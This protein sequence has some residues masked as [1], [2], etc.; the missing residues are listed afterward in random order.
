MAGGVAPGQQGEA[1]TVEVVCQYMRRTR[2]GPVWRCGECE[3]GVLDPVVGCECRVCGAKVVR[4]LAHGFDI[5]A[6]HVAKEQPQ[7][8]PR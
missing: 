3:R 7:E 6:V 2:R 5:R 8:Q 4:V 1:M